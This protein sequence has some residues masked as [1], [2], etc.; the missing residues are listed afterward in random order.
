[1][2]DTITGD[3]VEESIAA[4]TKYVDWVARVWRAAAELL[5]ENDAARL[6]GVSH[7]DLAAR[8]GLTNDPLA[9][10]FHGSAAWRAI[11]DAAK[12]LEDLYLAESD[13]PWHLKLTEEGRKGHAASLEQLWPQFFETYLDDDLAPFLEAACRLSEAR[14]DGFASVQWHQAEEIYGKLVWSW[15]DMDRVYDITERLESM[16]FIRTQTAMGGHIGVQPTYRGIVRATERAQSEAQ[17]TLR[18]LHSAGE[19][20]NVDFKRELALSR[21]KDKGEF[22]R[23][24]LGLGNVQIFGA[25]RFLVVGFEDKTLSFYATPDAGLTQ[26]RLEQVL[27]AYAKPPEIRVTR[28][29]WAG[30]GEALLIEILRDATRVPY[31]ATRDLGPLTAGAVYV[32]RGRHTVEASTDEIADLEADAA[33]ARG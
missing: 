28:A 20:T 4:R 32:R 26:E 1:V 2:Q 25:R 22:V 15:P 33:R 14:S 5:A 31:R 13:S 24:L 9:A 27:H 30:G 21:D 17:T 11:H 7:N 10:E 12:D 8:L 3:S 18:E 23:D 16:H 29:P 19:V 6:I